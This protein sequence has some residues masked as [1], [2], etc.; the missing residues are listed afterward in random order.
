MHKQLRPH[1]K[2]SNQKNNIINI[3]VY[4]SREMF[5]TGQVM[6]NL[7]DPSFKVETFLESQMWQETG[8]AHHNE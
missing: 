5:K 8:P 4:Y 7:E 3:Y 2:G 6:G 1:V